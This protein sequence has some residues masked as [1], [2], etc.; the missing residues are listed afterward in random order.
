MWQEALLRTPDPPDIYERVWT[1]HHTLSKILTRYTYLQWMPRA[2]LYDL[3][4][5]RVDLVGVAHAFWSSMCIAS[6]PGSC[7]GGVRTSLGMRLACATKCKSLRRKAKR[8]YFVERVRERDRVF[9]LHRT[10]GYGRLT[11][12][13]TCF[14]CF[15]RRCC[16]SYSSFS[17][18]TSRCCGCIYALS[19]LPFSRQASST[20]SLPSQFL[21][22][23][24]RDR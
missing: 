18:W 4:T 2:H 23:W 3:W 20:P 24:C 21:P 22:F 13:P 1:Q 19:S 8:M 9:G 16:L 12:R 6:F 10:R 11:R 15:A 14:I 5:N 7:V 17:T